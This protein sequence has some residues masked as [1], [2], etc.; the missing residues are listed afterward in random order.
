[1]KL[2]R[3]GSIILLGVFSAYASVIDIFTPVGEN[4]TCNT[5]ISM[6]LKQSYQH[7]P[8]ITASQ[9][10]ILSTQAQIEAAKWNYFPTPSVDFSQGNSGRRGETYRIDQP[11]WTGGRLDA[12][13]ELAYARGDEAKYTLGE[14]AYD[15]SQRVLNVLEVFI[16]ADGEV[17]AFEQGKKDLESLSKMLSRR[18]EAGVSSESDEALIESRMYQIESDLITAKRR[19]DMAKSQL[20]LLIGKK[21][22]CRINFKRDTLLHK[23]FTFREAEKEMLRTHPTLKKK[24]AQIAIAQAE[25][26]SADAVVM[27]NVSLRAEHQRGSLYTNDPVNNETVAYVAISF[28]PGAGFSA[29]SNIESAKYKVLQARDD[30]RTS[31]QVLKDG[32]LRDFSDYR[33]A[34][35]RLESVQH[36]ITSSKAVLESYKRLFLAGKKQW[37]DLVNA[38]REVT[39][40]YVTLAT[41]RASIIISAYRLSLD[42]G[43]LQFD[44][45]GK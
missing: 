14:S 30:L 12:M 29:M 17:K 27:P 36:M 5:Q 10:L 42:T 4:H 26:K 15:L 11:V 13:S 16:Q 43:K 2:Y 41:L 18:V 39:M 32:L 6:I 45:K 37:L 25:K 38:S 28:N 3:I 34:R 7:Y 23:A 19:Y 1:M 31:E 35:S 40:N 44:I 33:S 20:E 24:R 22:R 8:S 9:K 21:M